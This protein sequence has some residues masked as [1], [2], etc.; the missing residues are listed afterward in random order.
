MKK[1]KGINKYLVFTELEEVGEEEEE[2]VVCDAGE[3]LGA[4]ES[5]D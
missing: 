3:G 4:G 1:K 5:S 2:D